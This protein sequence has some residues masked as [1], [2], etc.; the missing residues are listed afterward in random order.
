M[1]F[2]RRV[3]LTFV[4]FAM[5]VLTGSAGANDYPS[6]PIRFVIATAP[7]GIIDL[8]SRLV[9]ERLTEAWGQQVLMDHRPGASGLIGTEFAAKAEP[10]GHTL[11]VGYLGP[12]AILPGLPALAGKINYDPIK[13]FAPVTLAVTL[14]NVVVVHPSVQANSIQELI[15]LCKARPGQINFASSGIGTGIHLA[16]EMFKMMTGVD[17]VHIIYKGSAPALTD[18]VGGRVQIMFSNITPALPFIKAGRLRAL[19]VTSATR[20]AIAPD[21]PT[22]AESGVPGYDVTSWV[23]FWAPAATP[24]NIITRLNTEIV[25]ALKNPRV[26]DALLAQGAD[27]VPMSPEQLDDFL[28]A[29]ITKWATVLKAA[30]IDKI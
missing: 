27:P 14:P 30:K 3:T 15:A 17:M 8:V 26:R 18:L 10:D 9:G 23:G 5:L 4:G 19:G 21:L 16:G 13:S 12:H 6:K 11:I 22:V 25:K 28:K 7:G 29:E 24:K 2:L 20:T 1:T